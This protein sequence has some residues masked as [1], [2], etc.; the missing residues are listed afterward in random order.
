M[1]GRCYNYLLLR[2]NVGLQNLNGFMGFGAF[3]VK[4]FHFRVKG[5]QT[6]PPEQEHVIHFRGP[7]KGQV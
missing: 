4:G 2:I 7:V 5:F 6:Q 1:T 3:R